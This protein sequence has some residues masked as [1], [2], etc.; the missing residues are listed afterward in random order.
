MSWNKDILSLLREARFALQRFEEDEDL[1]SLGDAMAMIGD[2]AEQV[3]LAAEE[4][5][6]EATQKPN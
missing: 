6:V 1:E 4:A 5:E 2:L 3:G